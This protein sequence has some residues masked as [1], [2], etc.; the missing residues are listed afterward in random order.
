MIFRIG[1]KSFHAL[2]RISE[3]NEGSTRGQTSNLAIRLFI[4]KSEF[5]HIFSNCLKSLVDSVYV[6]SRG[7]P[8]TNVS[9]MF[10]FSLLTSRMTM[11]PA[12]RHFVFC[13]RKIPVDNVEV[14]KCWKE[15]YTVLLIGQQ[16]SLK[17]LYIV[18]FHIRKFWIFRYSTS[19]KIK[20]HEKR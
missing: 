10:F 16:K 20:P 19:T 18:Y 11:T 4:R 17:F 3:K 7:C 1:N 5:R 8:Q 14:Q 12:G 15:F 2:I 6:I 13:G 9:V